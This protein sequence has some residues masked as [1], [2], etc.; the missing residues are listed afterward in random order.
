MAERDG[1]GEV[2]VQAQGTRD[3]P[4]DLS[5]F[6]RMRETRPKMIALRR[7][8]HLGFMR[9]PAK[10]LRVQDLVAV[11]LVIGAQNV[12]LGRAIPAFALIGERRICGKRLVLSLLLVFAMDDMHGILLATDVLNG[13]VPDAAPFHQGKRNGETRL[14]AD[15]KR[16]R[17]QAG[18]PCPA[19]SPSPTAR[20]ARRHLAR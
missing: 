11:A 2:F 1:L 15:L 8:E 12:R 7:Q 16:S 9:E 6:E 19:L 4:R 14:G 10:R 18:G 13:I 3:G 20:A 17:R 5:H